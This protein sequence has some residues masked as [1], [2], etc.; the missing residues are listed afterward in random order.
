MN[1]GRAFQ[2]LGGERGDVEGVVVET[3][4]GQGELVVVEPAGRGVADERTRLPAAQVSFERDGVVQPAKVQA[5]HFERDPRAG[6]GAPLGDVGAGSRLSSLDFKSETIIEGV[7]LGFVED[8][9]STRLN[10][11]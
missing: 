10:S 5:S 1:L 3:G 2:A 11:S 6:T 8:R 9:K 4:E 7:A